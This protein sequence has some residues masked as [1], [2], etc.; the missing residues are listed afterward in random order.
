MK[1]SIREEFEVVEHILQDAYDLL[2]DILSA[3][4]PIA[5]QHPSFTIL[6]QHLCRQL[7]H[8]I[9][10][11]EIGSSAL[12]ELWNGHTDFCEELRAVLSNTDND[13]RRITSSSMIAQRM[14]GLRCVQAHLTNFEANVVRFNSALHIFW[15]KWYGV[16][17]ELTGDV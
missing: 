4:L 15:E 16:A 8:I 1:E 12:A 9:R 5:R 11:L 14:Q 7:V 10:R 3:L 13:V 17:S 2:S 6:Q